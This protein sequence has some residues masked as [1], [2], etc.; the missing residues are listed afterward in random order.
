[1]RHKVTESQNAHISWHSLAAISRTNRASRATESRHG[2]TKSTGLY[3]CGR[4]G[5]G[6][7]LITSRNGETCLVVTFKF[8]LCV[9]LEVDEGR[10]G[11]V[12]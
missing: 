9:S 11:A 2:G 4:I 6:L 7:L 1:L 3:I 10:T 12:G 5:T 8:S